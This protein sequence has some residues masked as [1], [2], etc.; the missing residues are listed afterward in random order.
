MLRSIRLSS[1]PRPSGRHRMAKQ[2]QIS[3]V[4]RAVGEPGEQG[5]PTKQTFEPQV[6]PL[7]FGASLVI[8]GASFVIN[9]RISAAGEQ[10]RE[11]ES[12]ETSLRATKLANLKGEVKNEEHLHRQKSDTCMGPLALDVGPRGHAGGNG[13]LMFMFGTKVASAEKRLAVAQEAVLNSRV[14]S[15]EKRLAVAQEAELSSRVVASAEKRLA[16]AQEAEL[17]S[18]VVIS[19]FGT[20]VRVRVPRD[21]GTPI[22]E[23]EE[24]ERRADEALKNAPTGGEEVTQVEG[25]WTFVVTLL[26]V[27]LLTWFGLGLTF[28]PDPALLGDELSPQMIESMRAMDK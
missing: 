7:P 13:M 17:S 11:R 24:D 16:V 26:T 27:V 15:A 10:R 14:A 18:R 9:R 20:N 28:S 1:A 21:L 5:A 23:I 19:M 12:A 6:D 4:P 25:A 3:V 2:R 8:L 22:S